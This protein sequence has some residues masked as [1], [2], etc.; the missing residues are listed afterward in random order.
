MILFKTTDKERVLENLVNNGASM[1]KNLDSLNYMR[2]PCVLSRLRVGDEFI[3]SGNCPIMV[4]NLPNGGQR[5]PFAV[6][7]TKD[8]FVKKF[9]FSELFKNVV[10]SD[11]VRHQ[12][13]GTVTKFCC[14]R[15]NT[16]RDVYEELMNKSIKVTSVQSY[17]CTHPITKQTVIRNLYQ[18]DF[19]NY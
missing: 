8:N 1:I 19:I 9:Y 14:Q 12:T 7:R 6:V 4:D 3:L 15:C 11:G 18:Y 5:T 16:Y 2:I 13:E 10:S 17:E